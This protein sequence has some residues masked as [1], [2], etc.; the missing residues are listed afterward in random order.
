MLSAFLLKHKQIN[1][2]L[3]KQNETYVFSTFE[4]AIL[5]R[6]GNFR[7]SIYGFLCQ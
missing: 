5:P 7:G 1:L 3:P 2:Y 6:T 4:I